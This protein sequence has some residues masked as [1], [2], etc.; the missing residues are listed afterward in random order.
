MH[1]RINFFNSGLVRLCHM[2][3]RTEVLFVAMQTTGNF[4]GT[5][6]ISFISATFYYLGSSEIAIICVYFV[7]SQHQTEVTLIIGKKNPYSLN[8]FREK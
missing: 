5:L 7:W 1:K 3:R 6:Y 2:E 4:E 8:N